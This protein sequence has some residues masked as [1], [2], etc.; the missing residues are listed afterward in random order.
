MRRTL[1]KLGA[2]ALC[3]GLAW[4]TG[5][6]QAR[7][8][9]GP[10][11]GGGGMGRMFGAGNSAHGTVT[12]VSGNEITIRNEQG[13]DYKIVTGPNTHIRKDRAEAKFSDI[14][15]GDVIVAMG[16]VDGRTVGAAFVIVL[17]P[18]QAAE[19]KK[20]IAE[21]GK[22]WTAGRVTAINDLTVTIERPDKAMQKITVDE[23]TVFQKR[24]GGT[25]EDITF[26]EVK[27]GDMVN[28]RGALKG[29]DFAATNL[30]VMQPREHGQGRWRDG[31]G[32]PGAGG[33]NAKPA[34]QPEGTPSGSAAPQPPTGQQN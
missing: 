8:Q 24:G 4:G 34:P 13:D 32:Q 3:A 15:P 31:Q 28:A 30:T 23:N 6:L 22:T 16:N 7:A 21:F 18:Q 11:E 19:M 27:V 17:D 1:Q 25:Q 5:T 26:P 10:P 14:H 20:R 29:A 33:S 9:E 2:V 12:A